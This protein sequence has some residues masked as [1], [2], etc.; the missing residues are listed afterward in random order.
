MYYFG[1]QWAHGWFGYFGV[2]YTVLDLTVQDYLIRSADGLILPMVGVALA[3]LLVLWVHQLQLASPADTRRIVQRVL[4]PSST[5]VGLV[6]VSLAL[7]DV[8]DPVFPATFPEG[9]GLSLTIGVL[10]LAYAARLLRLLAAKRRPELLARQTPGATAVAEWGAV[11]VLVSIGLFWAVGDYANLV[12]TGR[13]EQLEALLPSYPNV[14]AYSE[15]R[16][17][18]QAPGIQEVAC[19]YPDAA[20]RFRYEGLKLVMQSG[21]Q[22][23]FLPAVWT[24]QRRGDITPT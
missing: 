9:R 18:L 16:L 10:L 13:A 22:Y 2:E 6:L 19:Q 12:G 23:L 21:N 4:M 8:V 24:R 14:A 20:Y 7:T 1:R 11:F 5:I 17:S 15:K 3:T